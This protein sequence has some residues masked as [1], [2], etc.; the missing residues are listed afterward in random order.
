[1]SFEMLC[2]RRCFSLSALD[3]SK[4]TVTSQGYDVLS[5]REFDMTHGNK[6]SH[7]ETRSTTQSQVDYS[8][9]LQK[10]KL[11]SGHA[12]HGPLSMHFLV[13]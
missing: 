13:S 9:E 1:M 4:S 3:S 5:D 2:L 11:V 10:G 7:D 12:L 8:E 6:G